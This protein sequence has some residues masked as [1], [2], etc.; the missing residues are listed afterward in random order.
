MSNK[1]DSAF[2]QVSTEAAYDSDGR[3]D[4]YA[5]THSV[6]GLTKR[7]YFAAMAMQGLCV[8]HERFVDLSE[9]IETVHGQKVGSTG[10][11]LTLRN[12]I[13]KMAVGHAD[14]LLAELERTK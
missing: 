5:N 4:L 10:N 8:S 6:G 7:E 11:A 2:P 12:L 14:A 9:L 3:G 13:A 1:N